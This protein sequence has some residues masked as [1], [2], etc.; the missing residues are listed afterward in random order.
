[1]VELNRSLGSAGSRPLSLCS[2]VL[3]ILYGM[4][5]RWID[6]TG[7]GVICYL[8][9]DTT[10]ELTTCFDPFRGTSSGVHEYWYQLLNSVINKYDFI[11]VCLGVESHLD[12]I[13]VT[14]WQLLFCP[15]G[16]G[17]SLTRE[18]VCRLSES[19][20]GIKSIVNMYNCLHFTCYV[21]LNVYKIYKYTRLPSIWAQYSRLCPISSSSFRNNGSQVNWTVVCLTAPNLSLWF[22]LCRGSPCPVLQTFAFHDFVWL[23]I[24]NYNFSQHNILLFFI[25]NIVLHVSTLCGHPRVSFSLY[26]YPDC[27]ICVPYT[28]HCL[29]IGKMNSHD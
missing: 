5:W 12:Q 23:Q 15:W 26:S 3:P 6:E 20:S 2:F 19:V 11:L 18:R 16:G 22:F 4:R 27:E 9:W 17:P 1:M 14:I 25:C 28:G 24:T 7:F 21:L 8:C 29:H 13:L 10:K